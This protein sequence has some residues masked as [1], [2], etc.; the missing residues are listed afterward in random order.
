MVTGLALPPS[1]ITIR[2]RLNYL[3]SCTESNRSIVNVQEATRNSRVKPSFGRLGQ[4]QAVLTR[5]GKTD[6]TSDLLLHIVTS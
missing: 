4:Y 3:G 1:D 2:W 5:T 6:F